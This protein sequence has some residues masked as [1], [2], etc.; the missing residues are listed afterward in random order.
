MRRFRCA[1]PR[2]DALKPHDG[3]CGAA[4]LP[5]VRFPILVL[6]VWGSL[7]VK[8]FSSF[9]WQHNLQNLL[10]WLL[11]EWAGAVAGSTRRPAGCTGKLELPPPNVVGTPGP[12]G[13]PRHRQQQPSRRSACA[14]AEPHP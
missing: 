10:G 14:G 13:R 3:A 9:E 7:T 5:D 1:G 12:A 8:D 6:A 4:A 2:P 11:S